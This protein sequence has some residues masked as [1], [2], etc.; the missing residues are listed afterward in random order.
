[1]T[2]LDFITAAA[3]ADARATS[4]GHP[5]YPIVLDPEYGLC[6]LHQSAEEP[7]NPSL[8]VYPVSGFKLSQRDTEIAQSSSKLFNDLSRY[9][10]NANTF[11]RDEF[12]GSVVA[13]LY[14]ISRVTGCSVVDSSPCKMI[15]RFG[16]A[17]GSD[18]AVLVVEGCIQLEI[19][20]WLEA[21]ILN[22][23]VPHFSY[24]KL[25]DHLVEKR[26]SDLIC[27]CAK[28]LSDLKA[29]DILSILRYFLVPTKDAYPTMG[30]IRKEWES[31]A[32]N[33]M[34]KAVDDSLKEQSLILAKES[35]ILL[36]MAYDDFTDS[37]LCLHYLFAATRADELVLTS[38]ISRLNGMEMMALIKYLGKWLRKYDRFP[39]VV[40]CPTSSVNS[41]WVPKIEDVVICLGLL[42]DEHFSTLVLHQEFHD[43][44][45]YL[46]GLVG[47]LVLDARLCCS[48]AN[49]IENLRNIK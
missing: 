16:Y 21:L 10:K 32:V 23:L 4:D 37:E 35:S 13:F 44:I 26:R 12:V 42:I 8:L 18:V 14:E 36:M 6:S 38:A 33:A 9:L 45:R 49:V 11:D 40:S 19:W 31:R 34:E 5:V 24:G 30:G 22:K 41:V 25:I 3:A 1:M 48:L 2:L 17:M 20:D 7:P 27:E 29:G 46:D 47:S 39:Q 15:G 28:N 43:E